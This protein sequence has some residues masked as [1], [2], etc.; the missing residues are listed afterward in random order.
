MHQHLSWFGLLIVLATATASS[1][2]PADDKPD[3]SAEKLLRVGSV[4]G[5][6]KNAP[7]E[8]GVVKIRTAIRY[9]EPNLAAQINL[10]REE[11]QLMLR[12]RIALRIRNPLQRQLEFIR[13]Y[14]AAQNM[15]SANLFT[16][17]EVQ[18]D[19]EFDTVDETK[20]RTAAPPVAFDDKGNPRKYT[21]AEL[22][23]LKG[24]EHLPGYTADRDALHVGQA[25]VV[26]AARRKLAKGE[27]ETAEE[28]PIATVIV[29]V[30]D[31]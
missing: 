3:L 1:A 17:K 9:L 16:L 11:Q 7:G 8:D 2:A 23:E 5:I 13:I 14:Q 26:T 15:G 4:R 18:K 21:S 28:K 27:K 31:P 29:I 19:L 10:L 12:Q 6:V 22:K 25:V 30:G 20:Y 24:T